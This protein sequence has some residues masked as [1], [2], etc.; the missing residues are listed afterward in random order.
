MSFSVIF[1]KGNNCCDFLFALLDNVV[2]LLK[3]IIRSFGNKLVSPSA[4][5]I[6]RGCKNGRVVS[7]E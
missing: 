7:F 4:D 1:T 5:P 2:L 6:L 3:E